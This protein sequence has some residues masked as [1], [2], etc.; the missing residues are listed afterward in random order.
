MTLCSL[1]A[2]PPF[3]VTQAQGSRRPFRGDYGRSGPFPVRSVI[4]R[5]A[6][7]TPYAGSAAGS[8]GL[9]ERDRQMKRSAHSRLAAPANALSSCLHKHLDLLRDGQWILVLPHS[10]CRPTSFLEQSDSFRVPFTGPCE[11]GLPPFGIGHRRRAV[12]RA[13]MPKAPV[14]E[15]GHIC[16]EEDYVRSASER[17]QRPSVHPVPQPHSVEFST[18]RQFRRS[19]PLAHIPHPPADKGRRCPRRWSGPQLPIPKLQT[20]MPFVSFAI[21]GMSVRAT[22]WPPF[23]SN[24]IHFPRLQGS[25]SLGGTA[26]SS[27]TREAE[28]STM[29]LGTPNVSSPSMKRRRVKLVCCDNFCPGRVTHMPSRWSFVDCSPAFGAARVG[30]IRG[31]SLISFL[32][33]IQG[34]AQRSGPALEEPGDWRARQGGG[35]QE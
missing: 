30:S 19:V 15:D 28:D 23:Q 35:R 10:D 17:R 1:G 3:V 5:G 20:E 33:A 24:T 27:I 11:L 4:L 21:A 12:F 6:C 14:Y 32:T 26:S 8:A 2:F 18:Q 16:A 34:S 22:A 13:G 31:T 9:S 7:S 29:V 25:E